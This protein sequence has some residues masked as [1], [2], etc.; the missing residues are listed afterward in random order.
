MNI[1]CFDSVKY[2]LNINISSMALCMTL[3]A[4]QIFLVCCSE[5]MIVTAAF[6]TFAFIAILVTNSNVN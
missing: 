2:R 3:I 5:L 4:I 6:V 1:Q